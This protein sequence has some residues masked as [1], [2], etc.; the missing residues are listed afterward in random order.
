[1][2]RFVLEIYE[3]GSTST[4]LACIQSAHAIPLAIGETLNTELLVDDRPKTALRIIAIE[5]TFFPSAEGWSSK[6]MV[7][8]DTLS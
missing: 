7:Y 4:V 2:E 3:P 6:R 5:N 8:T 1:M